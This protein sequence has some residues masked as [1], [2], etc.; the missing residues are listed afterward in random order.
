MS[1]QGQVVVERRISAPAAEVF[2]WWTDPQCMGRWMSPVGTAE[3]EV[4]LRVGGGFRVVMKGEGH[5]IEHIGE[6]REV[7]PPHRLVFTWVSPFT[8]PAPSLV[9][10]ELSPD[11]T[12]ATSL[13]ITHAELPA[14]AALSHGGGWRRMLERLD[15]LLGQQA[16]EPAHET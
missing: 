14:D 2:R 15:G 9:T 4:D 8:G 16:E 13:R 1:G 12:D 10:V 7:E 3:A 11:G 5:V 6:Y